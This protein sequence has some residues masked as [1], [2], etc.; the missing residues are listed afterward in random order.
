MADPSLSRFTVKDAPIH[1]LT[2]EKLFANLAER[3]KLYAHHM[4][5]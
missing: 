5:R 4:S 1:A 3:E 2:V